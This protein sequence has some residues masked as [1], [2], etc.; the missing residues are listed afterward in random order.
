MELCDPNL[1][2]VL[3]FARVCM[4]RGRVV[5]TLDELGAL[6]PVKRCM[7]VAQV[8]HACANED[9]DLSRRFLQIKVLDRLK[10]AALQ[11]KSAQAIAPV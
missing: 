9:A 4:L 6:D 2:P 8:S 10:E 7:L 3:D 11:R 5:V 1:Q